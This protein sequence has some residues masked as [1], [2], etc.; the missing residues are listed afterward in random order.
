VIERKVMKNTRKLAALGVASLLA[1]TACS[2]GASEGESETVTLNYWLWDDLQLPLYQECADDFTAANPNITVD[3]TQTGW[4]QYWQNLSTQITAGTAPDVFV[5]QISYYLQ[6]VKNNQLLDLTEAVEASD[7]DFSDYR[8]GLADRWVTD[9][10]RYGLPK[11]WDTVALLYNVEAATEAGYTADQLKELT[12]NPEDGGTF[13]E[14]IKAMTIDGSGRNGLDPDFDKSN[15]VRYGYYPEWADGAVG[16]SGWGNFAHSSGFTYTDDEGIPTT[17]N[18]DSEP[19]IETGAWMRS[20]IEDGYAPNFDSQS[21][22]GTQAVMENQNVASTIT[23][24]WTASTYLAEDTPV[25]FAYAPLPEGPEGRSAATNGLAD[26]VWAGTEHPEEATQ[27]VEYLSSAE[28]QD[29]VGEAGVI[30]PARNSA[31]DVAL[32]ARDAKG[33]DS[34]AFTSVADAGD[35]WPIPAFERS[36]EVNSAVQDAMQA[37]AQGDDPAERL[38]EANETVEALFK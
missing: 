3:I 9:G 38:K 36:A 20:L 26:S 30:F 27:W 28:C 22:L 11:D 18:F 16:Q 15:V 2:S 7:I 31:T 8:E 17:F 4:A 12:W 24:S 19:L 1:L 29:K 14:L 35:T 23:G 5:N 33:L 13:G 21:T 6:F 34:S 32:A 25:E 37:V 10:K